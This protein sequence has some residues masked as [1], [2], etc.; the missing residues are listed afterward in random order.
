MLPLYY[1]FCWIR[2]YGGDN[3]FEIH[4]GVFWILIYVSSYGNI[5]ECA[6]VCGCVCL[7]T[8]VRVPNSGGFVRIQHG[9]TARDLQFILTYF[10]SN[11]VS[12]NDRKTTAPAK[13]GRRGSVDGTWRRQYHH[14][15]LMRSTFVLQP[16]A[17]EIVGE[18]I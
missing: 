2:V 6:C 8:R 9:R 7:C 12:D 1:S 15:N 4:V 14:N 17:D 13:R 10:E 3:A 5:L 16:V 18:E 11:I